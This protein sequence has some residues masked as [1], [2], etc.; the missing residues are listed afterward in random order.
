MC[1]NFF[2]RLFNNSEKY[3][4]SMKKL[5]AIAISLLISISTIFAAH[6]NT[7]IKDN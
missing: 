2:Q 7:T 5:S 6:K 3:G 4:G 1:Y